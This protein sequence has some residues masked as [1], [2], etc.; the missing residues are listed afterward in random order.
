MRNLFRTH[1]SPRQN[2]RIFGEVLLLIIAAI[3]LIFMGRFAYIAATGHIAGVDLTKRS[4]KKYEG[5]SVI[6]AQRGTIYDSSG[7]VLA[8]DTNA[9]A[10]YAVLS[11]DYVTA[12]KKPLYVADKKKTAKALSK[13]LPMSEANIYK[14]LTPKNKAVYQVEF[15][16]A[17]QNL[18]LSIKRKI[19]KQ[20]LTGIYFK[21]SPTRLYPNG[22]FASHVVG[23]AQT[24]KGSEDSGSQDLVGVM[25]V[26]KY[27]NEQLTGQDGYKNLTK[28]SYGYSI[29]QNKNKVKAAKN[30]Q[31]VYL[32]LDSRMQSY[33][34]SLLSKVNKKYQPAS[35]N[36]VLMNAK[37]GEILAASQRP[38]FNAS[39]KK[40]IGDVWR[41]TLV[42]DGYEPGSVLKI[43]TLSAAIDSGHYNPDQYYKSGSV[44]VSGKKIS[45]WQTAGWGM[46]PLNQAFARSSNVG[47]VKLEQEMGAKTWKSY[48]EKFGFLKKTGIELPGETAGTLQ[49]E[50]PLD[51]A[52]TSFGQGINVNVMQM[53]QMTSAIANNGTMIKPQILAGVGQEQ[54]ITPIKA[55]K[56]IKAS[57]AKK[58]MQNMEDVVYKDYGTGQVYQIP[59]YKIAAKTGTAQITGPNGGYLTGASNYIFSVSGIAPADDP[60]YI[61]YITMKQPGN[62]TDSA[63]TI[64]SQVFNPM[65][66]RALEY[67]KEA[68][69]DKQQQVKVA[70]V[71]SQSTKDAQ[72]K[73]EAQN[74]KTTL[75]GSGNLVVQQL[76]KAGSVILPN[77]RVLLMTN[78]AMT[79]PDVNGWSKNDLLKLAQLTGIDVDIKG[80]GY[81]YHQSLAVNSLLDGVKQ[82]KVQL[83]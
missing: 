37:T 57:T 58:V 28:D 7:N 52:T 46:I 66:K 9:Y 17:G 1:R 61:L 25:G 14:Q 71:L 34:E 2:R 29:N 3:F 75:V 35:M 54:Q 10:V 13:Y 39:T 11:H 60:K 51:Q 45:D 72:K 62:M 38:T 30:G 24:P 36:A 19:E 67:T 26:E 32:T 53:L 15:G 82:I 4:N 74:L 44:L 41:D 56:P 50:R 8:Q 55:G 81:A 43:A 20:H 33:L 80:S 31:D 40:G 68:E 23:I 47:M 73:L 5:D 77:Q 59:G 22:T 65:M 70:S 18:S 42:E 63:E 12:D 78:G 16:S 48:I 27:F 6:R 69:K 21:E 83:K 76:P 79:M 49:Y 64:L